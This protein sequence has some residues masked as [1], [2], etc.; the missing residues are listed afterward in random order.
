MFSTQYQVKYTCT[1]CFMYLAGTSKLQADTF[2]KRE[3]CWKS[4]LIKGYPLTRKSAVDGL[5]VEKGKC[6]V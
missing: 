1:K 6:S 5:V 3:N 2:C 4:A